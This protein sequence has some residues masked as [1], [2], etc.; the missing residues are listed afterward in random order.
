M[1]DLGRVLLIGPDGMLGRAFEELLAREAVDRD[2]LLFPEFDLRDA[3]SVERGVRADVDTVINCAAWT[4]VD[5]AEAREEEATA[6]NGEGV[7]RLAERCQRVGALL[8]HFSTDYVFDGNASTP[9]RTDQA[10][11]PVN[12]YGRSK[13]RGEELIEA[14]GGEFL[15]IR[16]SWLYAPW[17]NNFVRTISRLA[18][19]RDSLRVVD[20]QRGRPT[21]A[22]H[23]A[24]TTLEL[25]RA[26][27]LGTF[28]A[29]DG[30]QCS[31]YELAEEVVRYTNP[32]C[33]VEACASSEFPRPAPRPAYS[34]LDLG[35]T[36]ARLG[37]AM[38]DWRENLSRVAGA[39]EPW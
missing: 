2:T 35:K 27:A 8:V 7:G 34:V 10:R 30:G 25:I 39:L 6:I 20:D 13:A 31:W 1:R 3:R 12:A 11:A 9:Y 14:R 37:R 17:A 26:G 28:H 32:E 22:Q 5:G 15:V 29:T 38:P 16:T 4:D 33:R 24:E 23:L 18:T 36:E 19:Q 21:S